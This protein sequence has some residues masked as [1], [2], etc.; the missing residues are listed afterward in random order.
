[1]HDYTMA[2][3]NAVRQ[4]DLDALRMLHA[5]GHGMNACNKFAESLVH[6]AGRSGNCAV[7]EFLID[8]TGPEGLTICDDYGRTPLHDACW[9]TEPCFD[10]VSFILDHDSSMLM[11]VDRRGYTPLSYVKRDQWGAWHA[12]IDAVKDKYWPT[13]QG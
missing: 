11:V 7:M 3:I 13:L 2:T 5:E 4:A 12:F 9:A 6:M 8:C 1:M 10:L